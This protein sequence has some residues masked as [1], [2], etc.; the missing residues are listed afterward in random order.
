MDP[1]FTSR[2][3]LL[4]E[5]TP[6]ACTPALEAF[7]RRLGGSEPVRVPVRPAPRAVSGWCYRNVA[8]A[9]AGHG[10]RAVYGWTIWTCDAFATAEFHAVHGRADET[11]VDVTP[12]EDGE[13]EILFVPDPIYGGDFDFLKRPPNVRARMYEGPSAEKRAGDLIAC[14]GSAQLRHEAGRAARTGMTLEAFVASRM[15]PDG[16]EVAIDR[17]LA[18]CDE[19]ESLLIPTEQGQWCNDLPRYR[20]LES[21]RQ[22]LFWRMCRMWEAAP[23]RRIAV[24]E[25]SEGFKP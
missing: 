16:L 18:C 22:D 13:P 8:S 12:K 15:K 11:L 7:V 4:R 23:A 5:T 19:A 17:F 2:P 1:I 20:A 10:G 24:N 14:M 9:V 21:K 25:T 6:S 3:Y